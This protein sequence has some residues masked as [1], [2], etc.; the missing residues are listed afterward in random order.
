MRAPVCMI[1]NVVL[2]EDGQQIM[3]LDR[4]FRT[5]HMYQIVRTG[6][7]FSLEN[8]PADPPMQKDWPFSERDVGEERPWEHGLVA[9]KAGTIVGFTAFTHRNWNRR[10]EIWHL[11]VDTALRGHGIGRALL[12]AVIAA[13][14]AAQTRCVWLESSTVA[15]PAIRFYQHMGFT[16]CGLD[17]S[18][19]DAKGV[20]RAETALYFAYDLDA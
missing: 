6:W 19:Y 13:A 14:R 3:A 8:V 15:Y 11:Y 5:V 20:L 9:E 18:L 4:S 10:T 2:P 1:R 16:L 12:Q 7:S 17:T